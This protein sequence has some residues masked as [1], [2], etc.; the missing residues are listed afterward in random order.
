MKLL[1]TTLL[2]GYAWLALAQ[3]CTGSLTVAITGSSTGQPLQVDATVRGLYCAD[4]ETG[5]ALLTATGGN[6]R[7]TFDWPGALPD[8]A[9]LNNLAASSYGVIVSDSLKCSRT[10]GVQ[11]SELDPVA[12]DYALATQ[13]ACGSCFLADGGKPYFYSDTTYLAQIADLPDNRALANTTVCTFFDNPTQ[14]CN[15]APQLQRWWTVEAGDY[16]GQMRLFATRAELTQLAIES[17]LADLETLLGTESLCLL[18]YAGGPAD[19]ESFDRAE[20]FSQSADALRVYPWNADASIYALEVTVTG[21][22]AFYLQSC[23]GEV[24]PRHLRLSGQRG[25]DA[26]ALTFTSS[27]RPEAIDFVIERGRIASQFEELARQPGTQSYSGVYR[28]VDGAPHEGWNY[29][30]IHQTHQNGTV[31]YSNVVAFEYYPLIGL[32]VLG[33]PVQTEVHVR[34]SAEAPFTGRIS[35]VDDL[36]RRYHEQVVAVRK[37]QQIFTLPVDQFAAESYYFVVDNLDAGTRKT[38]KFEKMD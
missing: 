38:A 20:L 26:V 37:G 1:F 13:D 17:G 3:T 31:S 5:Q 7:Y 16:T 32:S 15:G 19:C 35:V 18:K 23:T 10:I 11:I 29:Y 33:N 2:L 34:V 9:F 8:S 27:E 25:V 14:Y 4:S 6:G 22:A 21:F 30:R 28:H 12:E 24:A 36:G